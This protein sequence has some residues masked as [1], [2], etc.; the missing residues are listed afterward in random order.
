MVVVVPFRVLVVVDVNETMVVKSYP[1][2]LLR[3]VQLIHGS[4]AVRTG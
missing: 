4:P 3:L 1:V 2:D